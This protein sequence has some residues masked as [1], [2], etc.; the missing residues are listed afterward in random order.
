MVLK[1]CHTFRMDK[2]R[3]NSVIQDCVRARSLPITVR[4]EQSDAIHS[5][6]VQ[7]RDTILVLPTGNGKSLAFQMLPDVIRAICPSKRSV[8]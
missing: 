7:K 4:K 1:T 3:F 2:E 5:I 8:I 6:V